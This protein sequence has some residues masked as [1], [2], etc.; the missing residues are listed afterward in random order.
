MY[1]YVLHFLTEGVR[2]TT[3]GFAVWKL[4]C[5]TAKTKT[6]SY[7]PIPGELMLEGWFDR[8]QNAVH[9]YLSIFHFYPSS[10]R[11][12]LS[13]RKT[14]TTNDDEPNYNALLVDK[15]GPP[16]L[17]HV[18]IVYMVYTCNLEIVFN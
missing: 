11:R 13:P 2:N 4:E 7:Y 10:I 16:K 1:M 17:T 15:G 6:D 18:N 14:M 3:R 5:R 9:W 8:E 12:H